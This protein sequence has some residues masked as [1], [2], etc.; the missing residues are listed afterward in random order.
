M[1]KFKVKEETYRKLFFIPLLLLAFSIL[2]VGNA[3]IQ[4]NLLELDID[5]KGGVQISMAYTTPIDSSSME[6]QLEEILGT[7]DV[8]VRTT[9]DLAGAQTGIQIEA[10]I[11]DPVVFEEAVESI[12]GIELNDENRSITN[13]GSTLA[14]SFWRQARKA[15]MWSVLL[16]CAII[17]FGFKRKILFGA[18][19]LNVF[20]DM[21]TTIAFMHIFN[22]Q[23]SLASIAA[24][25][26]ILGT[27][28]DSN[29]LLSTR[30]FRERGGQMVNRINEALVT[31][32]TMATTLLLVLSSI[33]IFASAPALKTITSVLL[34]GMSVD[35]LYTW[36]MNVNVLLRWGKQ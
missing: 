18:I 9:S 17:F 29:I 15:I 31:G 26:M 1:D 24:L 25:L 35:T 34:I 4:G 7:S 27:G 6:S 23:L 21:I 30:A 8:R 10:G 3:Y 22:I 28:V 13:F 12:L 33:L 14:S 5:L 32:L 16:M 2:V 19:L 20:A 11:E 36:T